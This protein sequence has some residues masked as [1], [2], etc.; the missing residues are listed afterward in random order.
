MN[1]VLPTALNDSALQIA[2]IYN[3]PVDQTK[4]SEMFATEVDSDELAVEIAEALR[5]YG[6]DATPQ[7]VSEKNIYQVLKQKKFDAFFN[8]CDGDKLYMRVARQLEKHRKVFT[9]SGTKVFALTVDKAAS[10]KVFEQVNVPTPKWQ[11]FR[12]GTE[13]LHTDLQFPLIVK[14]NSEDCSVGITQDSVVHDE[15][16]MRANIE[17]IRT[18]YKQGA[19]VEEFIGGREI[20]CT[21]VGNGKNAEVFPLSEIQLSKTATPDN[22][23][24]DYNAKWVQQAEELTPSCVCPAP[25][26][27]AETA[28]KI[29]RD[30]KKAFIALQMKDYG[31]FDIRYNT[32]TKQWYFLEANANP[33]I[34]NTDD[35]ATTLA[36]QARGLEYEA[37]IREILES[38]RQRYK[39]GL[40]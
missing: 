7:A 8:L 26:I 39:V 13:K 23:V 35:E 6:Y 16:H 40:D 5:K 3:P 11:F 14:P 20:H 10:K 28:K 19:L 12:T 22:F 25:S 18:K 24:Y 33:S 32:H 2:V 38:C 27:D 4:D 31:R 17:M 9:G 1:T 15:E 36:A 30:A 29:Q 34:Q 21:V 37:F